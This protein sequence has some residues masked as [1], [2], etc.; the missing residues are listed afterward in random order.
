MCRKSFKNDLF[1][2]VKT[3]DLYDKCLTWTRAVQFGQNNF[4]LD[5][6]RKSPGQLL[7][8]K[9]GQNSIGQ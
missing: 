4:C 2:Y 9:V 1:T 6:K 7:G 8:Q 5:K 3:C